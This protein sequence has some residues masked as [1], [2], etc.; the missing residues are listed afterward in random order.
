[1]TSRRSAASRDGSNWSKRETTQGDF[2]VVLFG[3][4]GPLAD[5]NQRLVSEKL[6]PGNAY[7]LVDALSKTAGRK[8]AAQQ[9]RSSVQPASN[10]AE[11]AFHEKV[12]G[13]RESTGKSK[14]S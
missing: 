7:A 14:G 12:R 1:M 13:T 4:V 5:F 10:S 9:P 8:F 11:V 6:R 2:E 3:P